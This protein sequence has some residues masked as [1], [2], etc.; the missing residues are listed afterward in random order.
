MDPWLLLFVAIISYL[1]GSISFGRVLMRLL[2]P[3]ENLE[4]VEMPIP[5]VEEK[6]K[7]ES[8]GGNTVSLKLGARAGCAVGFLDILK[9]FIPTLAF[10]LLYPDQ[11]YFLVAALMAFVG[12]NWPVFHHFKGGRGISPF[13]GGLFGFDPIGAVVV[14][15]ASML[16]GMVIFKELLIAYAGGVILLIPWLLITKWGDPLLVYYM[17]YCISISVLFIVAMIP[18]VR[19]II[20]LRRKYGKV[21]MHLSMETFPMGQQ[22]LKLM[23]RLHLVKNEPK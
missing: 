21:D 11:P 17:V 3:G 19:Q 16:I 7:L 22:M 14:A 8:V 10:R 1:L 20:A 13:Y 23:Q 12:H 9:A 2:K 6:Y 5:G 15:S 18:E 4:S